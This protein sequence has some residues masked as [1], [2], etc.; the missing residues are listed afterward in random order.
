MRYGTYVYLVSESIIFVKLIVQVDDV[1]R[2]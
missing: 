1:P 2:C